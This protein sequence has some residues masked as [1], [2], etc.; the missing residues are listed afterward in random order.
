MTTA[1]ISKD[2]AM[3]PVVLAV[4]VVLLL[5]WTAAAPVLADDRASLAVFNLRPTNMEAMG[6]DADLLYA[7]VDQLELHAATIQLM[8][9]REME[10]LLYHRGL[11][12]A[13]NPDLVTQAGKALGVAYILF[14]EVTKKGSS[15]KAVIRL[16]DIHRQA[17]AK[18]WRRGFSG[19]SAISA[20]MP[21]LAQEIV[22]TIGVG[23]VASGTGGSTPSDPGLP[24]VDIRDL[25]AKLSDGKVVLSWAFDPD[26]PIEDFIVYRSD[27]QSGPFQYLGK[28]GAPPFEDTGIDSGRTY[29]YRLGLNLFS[30]QEVRSQLIAEAKAR[31]GNQPHPPLILSIAGQARWCEIAFV[32]A[33]RNQKENR[34]IVSY[35]VFRQDDAESV[36]RRIGSV[37]AGSKL[38][39]QVGYTYKDKDGLTDGQ[40]YLYRLSSVDKK[41][42]E[43]PPSD[44][45]SATTT[46]RPELSVSQD[47]L[48]RQVQL[49]WK[50]VD[51]AQG[52][53]L[54]RQIV[55]ES[56]RKVAT[57]QGAAVNRYTDDQNGLVDGQTYQYQLSAY[58]KEGET[59]PSA[60]VTAVTK[61][62]MP[63]PKQVQAASGLVKSVQ[64]D[65]QPVSDPDVIGYAVYRAEKSTGAGTLK[66]ITTVKGATGFLDKGDLFVPLKDGTDYHYVVTTVNRYNAEGD[67]SEVVVATTKPRPA[68]V[69]GFIAERDGAAIAVSW[70]HS[71]E[72]DIFAQT[73]DRSSTSGFWQ[74]LGKLGPKVNRFEDPDVK[75]GRTYRYR[76]VV[77]DADGLKSDP[78]ESAPLQIPTS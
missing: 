72:K 20:E 31:S 18:E 28:I 33:L 56:W 34:Q 11:V 55:G 57:I 2:G 51:S 40:Q 59:G 71:P 43:S 63:S 74:N 3:K 14:G 6:L 53:R 13:D 64:L 25:K 22:D 73:L 12:Q 50:P 29:Y 66:K 68:A 77:E 47:G 16:M 23:N 7:L 21:A 5:G 27:V 49:S 17:V 37:D 32:P 26:Q 38:Q 30:G 54:Y 9:R 76:I 58:D 4:C 15:I 52:Y 75:S 70:Q 35:K 24:T 10:D 69:K 8:P 42:Q 44:A 39:F 67:Q 41:G 78:V 19:L 36:S 61:A 46:V 1:P 60:A 65:W 62:P 48:L 45:V